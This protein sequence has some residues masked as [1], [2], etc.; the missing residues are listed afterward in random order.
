MT[1]VRLFD[2]PFSPKAP[3]EF[4]A[5]S[6]G[7]WLLQHYGDAPSVTVQ[8]YR[9][10]PSLETEITGNVQAL[11]ANDAEVYTVLQSP[12]AEA[13]YAAVAWV[14]ANIGTIAAIYSIGS[15]L[16]ASGPGMPA[17]V[18]RT[19]ASPNNALAGRE[20]Q[21][22]IRQRIEDI[23]GTV[24]AI[25]TQIAPTY[26]KYIGNRR[27]EFGYYG[28]TR[29]YAE[30]ADVRDG[31][32][33]V[34]DLDG[35]SAAFYAP[36]TS[37]NSG[38]A[39]QLLIGDPI[40]DP[41]LTVRRSSEIDG[42]GIVLKAE[43]QVQL[44]ASAEYTFIADP[45]GDTIEQSTKTPNF[46]AVAEVG[47][48][49]EIAVP[50]VTITLGNG[51]GVL[52]VDAADDTIASDILNA[53][54]DAGLEIGD[55][56]VVA[57]F[58]IPANNG[59]FT[60]LSFPDAYKVELSG[61][62]RT[63][64]TE[65]AGTASW[66]RDFGSTGTREIAAVEDGRIVLV[67]ATWAGGSD[68]P[69]TAALQ[70]SGKDHRTFWVTIP[71]VD[72]TEVWVNIV[73]QQGMFRDSGGKSYTEVDF[74]IQIEELDPDDLSPTGNV[75]TVAGTIGGQV[76]DEVAQ[77]VEHVTGWVGPCRVRLLRT[78]LYDYAFNGAI[79]DE[80]KV[81]DL[82]GVSPVDREDFGCITTVQTVT[83]ATARA[84]AVRA[85]QLNCLAGRKLPIWSGTAW[86]GAFDADGRLASGTISATSR[87]VDILPAV[88]IDPL[89]GNRD[90][91]EVDMAQIWS[92]QQQLDD[93]HEDA[94]NF[95]YTFDSDA[96]TLEETIR[97]IADAAFCRAMR[98]NGK[99]RLA[100]D[101]QQSASARLLTHRNKKPQ[102]ETITRTFANDSGFDGVEFVYVDPDTGQS[103]TIRLPQDGSALKPRRFELPGIRSFAKAW[104]RANREYRKLLGQ[105]LA[106]ETGCL[107]DARMLL[108][109]QRVDIVDNTRYKS[110]DGDVVGVDGLRLRL[111]QAVEFTPG[112]DHSIVLM[113]RDGTLE[114]IVCTEGSDEQEVVLATVPGEAV[115][116]EHG[117]DGVRT[118]F[119][120]AADTT[121]DAMAFL[122]DEVEPPKDRYVTVRAVNYS[123]GYYAMDTEPIPDSASVIN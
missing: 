37:P 54:T 88:M 53:W 43:N 83:P 48:E 104:L 26:A 98:V 96:T 118:I 1:T 119:S 121:R 76:S 65:A 25:P 80:I 95:D 72:R 21:V 114:S 108:P 89:I 9:G 36:F 13:I 57:G 90:I 32:T 38:D 8:I 117:P 73:A 12:G 62:G 75:E 67:G 79:V 40:I 51:N 11:L 71:T 22:R 18:N 10:A 112:A 109:Y 91:A 50:T 45:G 27:V 49:I 93:L 4:E 23:F 101:R 123:D 55:S 24:R 6:I 3:R 81:L 19:S 78:T 20:N 30:I 63:T 110:F 122:V 99:V 2:H 111:S 61:S 46:N 102:A 15:A 106:I 84:A 64:E 100:L 35:S 103:E 42:A 28:V 41:V 16:L 33:A 115:V 87:I 60:V 59:T 97:M 116:T 39:P 92:V 113:R 31:D 17:N 47:D 14:W 5:P 107:M 68:G 29:G 7:D 120:F 34:A 52:T 70:L 69:V 66:T 77:T 58:T 94:G 56:V 44:P 86:S 85:R 74:E 82:S 105:R